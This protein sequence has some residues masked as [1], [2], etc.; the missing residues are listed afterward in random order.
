[1]CLVLMWYFVISI[2]LKLLHLLIKSYAWN[3]VYDL[4]KNVIIELSNFWSIITNLQFVIKFS[5]NTSLYFNVLLLI[6]DIS[7]SLDKILLYVYIYYN[8]NI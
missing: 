6:V 2:L 3:P 5:V 1:M 4:L 8:R 7:N